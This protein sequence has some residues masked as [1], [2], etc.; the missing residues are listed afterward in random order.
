MEVGGI[1]RGREAWL[2]I[3]RRG[4]I[5]ERRGYIQD[6]AYITVVSV[7][8]VCVQAF[9]QYEPVIVVSRDVVEPVPVLILLSL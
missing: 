9:L 7:D 2:C 4:Y 6:T 5:Q 3:R 8:V 1:G